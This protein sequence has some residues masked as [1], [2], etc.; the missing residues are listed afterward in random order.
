[1]KN[2]VDAKGKPVR[3]KLDFPDVDGDVFP[4]LEEEM[5]PF[6]MEDIKKMSK[7]LSCIW[8]RFLFP[9]CCPVG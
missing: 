4:N 9:L 6:P 5:E 3:W 2:M 8:F 7:Y 1:M